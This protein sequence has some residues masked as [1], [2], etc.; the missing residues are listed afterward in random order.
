MEVRR[1]SA[2]FAYPL[3]AIRPGQAVLVAPQ[4]GEPHGVTAAMACEL[5]WRDGWDVS[6]EFPG[7]DHRLRELVH[8][9]WFDVLDLSLSGACRRDHQL[10]AMAVSIRAAQAASLNPALAVIVNGRTFVES[11]Q[12]SF[13]VGADA[14]CASV[15]ETVAAAQR[16]LQTLATQQRIAQALRT[17]SRITPLPVPLASN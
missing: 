1:L 14:V 5:F 15:A 3:H 11:P 4:P 13:A 9:H 2:G 6:C 12:A 8:D 10:Q 16:V 7:S 17:A